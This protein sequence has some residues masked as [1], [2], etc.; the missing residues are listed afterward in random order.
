MTRNV[1][2]QEKILPMLEKLIP[3]A[4]EVREIVESMPDC[5]RK[6][7]L[8]LTVEHLEKKVEIKASE[9][10]MS[11]KKVLEYINSNPEFQQK[12][13][14]AARSDKGL[15]DL[16]KEVGAK[17]NTTEKKVSSKKKSK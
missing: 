17:V 14:N 2:K 3:L 7:S 4:K 5:T 11:D 10:G 9:R 12:L 1:V 16:A 13:A 15:I 6:T 8:L